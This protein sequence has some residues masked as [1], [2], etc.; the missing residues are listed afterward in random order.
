MSHTIE[1]SKREPFLRSRSAGLMV[2]TVIGFLWIAYGASLTKAPLD[3]IL[4]IVGLGI[5]ILL[6]SKI[7]TIRKMS[8]IPS[9]T[10]L[11]DQSNN[12][13]KRIYFIINLLIEIALL[14]LVYY[15]L[16]KYHRTDIIL[17]SIAIVVGF[18]FIPMALFLKIKQ[19]YICATIMILSGFLFIIINN[20]DANL[21]LQII[22]AIISAFALWITVTLSIREK[23]RLLQCS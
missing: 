14:N 12:R 18:H 2:G 16:T 15:Y 19:Y 13:N 1:K 23:Q 11:Q 22:Q 6:F 10:I 4:F 21:K 8:F 7:R 3:F 9:N 5:T 20:A 17:F